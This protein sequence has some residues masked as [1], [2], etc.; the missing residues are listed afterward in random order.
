MASLA[1]EC[2][3]ASKPFRILVGPD[4]REFMM[5][6]ELLANMS[7]PLGAL[8]NNNMKESNEGVVEWPEFDEG[9]FVRFCQFA[10]TGDYKDPMLGSLPVAKDEPQKNEESSR[11]VEIYDPWSGKYKK[12]KKGQTLWDD[13]PELPPVSNVLWARF[14]ESNYIVP[15]PPSSSLELASISQTSHTEAFLSHARLYVL[16]DYYDIYALV[17]LSLQKLHRC[18]VSFNLVK[19]TV[20]DIAALVDYSYQNT[21]DK[22]DQ[23]DRLRDLLARYVACKIELM[24]KSSY[25]RELLEGSGELSKAVIGQMLERLN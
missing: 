21:V 1:F 5:H 12:K 10:Y 13:S 19:E 4:K 17:M 11:Q 23:G 8:V 20:D 2:I 24:W 9:T 3:A 6:S 15:K 25:F 7:K 14:T 16:A 22:G 18:L